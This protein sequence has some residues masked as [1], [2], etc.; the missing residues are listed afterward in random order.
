MAV[1]KTKQDLID[2]LKGILNWELF[3]DEVGDFTQIFEKYIPSEASEADILFK[4]VQKINVLQDNTLQQADK[5]LFDQLVAFEQE[6]GVDETMKKSIE[7]LARQLYELQIRIILMRCSASKDLSKGKAKEL[8]IGLSDALTEKLKKV[9]QMYEQKT[10]LYKNMTGPILVGGKTE[11]DY[12]S[13]YLKYKAKY[14]KSKYLN[15]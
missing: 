13:K 6:Y 7:Q 2:Y 14:L 5:N 12:E 8:F 15:Y 1:H 10:D 11:N 4:E 3:G 9:N